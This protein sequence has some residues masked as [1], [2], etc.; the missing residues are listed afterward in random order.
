M[1]LTGEGVAGRG[2]IAGFTGFTGFPG[3]AGFAVVMQNQL[4]FTQVVHLAVLTKGSRALLNFCTARNT[5][6]LAAPGWQPSTRLTSSIHMP[7]KCRRTNAVRSEG[8]NSVIASATRS[9]VSPLMAM[10]SG[11]V[12]YTHLRA[13]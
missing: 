11:A 13:H 4:F 7:S 3:F 5:L 1:P 10:R 6:C 8:L 12:S 9:R 2:V